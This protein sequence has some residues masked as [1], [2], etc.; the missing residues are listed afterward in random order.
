[1]AIPQ[2]LT[3]PLTDEQ[4]ERVEKYIPFARS[5]AAAYA[6]KNAWKIRFDYDVIQEAAYDALVVTASEWTKETVAA[7]GGKPVPFTTRVASRF[8]YDMMDVVREIHCGR[9]TR[10]MMPQRGLRGIGVECM[11]NSRRRRGPI[12]PR[13]KLDD[14]N[15]LSPDA[16]AEAERI[17]AET[18]EAWIAPLDFR[19]RDIFRRLF[20]LGESQKEIVAALGVSKSRVSYLY[21]E[22]L[23]T[24]REAHADKIP[25]RA[26]RESA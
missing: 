16:E 24:L 6:R 23:E 9:K 17:Q 8:E 26:V 19:K 4:R 1:M 11:V 3:T 20:V 2:K 7:K 13:L 22:A 10:R 21:K 25:C 14:L 18:F 5:I 15:I 12:Q